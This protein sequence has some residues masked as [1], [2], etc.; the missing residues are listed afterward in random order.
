MPTRSIW[1]S[2]PN[3]ISI[4]ELTGPITVTAKTRYSQK[5]AEATLYPEENGWVRAE[6]KDPQ[7]AV[8]AG[9][10]MVFYDGEKVV[11]GATIE[12]SK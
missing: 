12:M 2:R 10:A 4:P 9:Q 6:F 8:T 3:W 11:G 7:R 1:G 5:E